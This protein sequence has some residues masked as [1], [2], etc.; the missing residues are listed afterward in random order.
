MGAVGSI[1]LMVAMAV[2]VIA[3]FNLNKEHL[4]LS[5]FRHSSML[6]LPFA[7][8]NRGTN[9]WYFFGLYCF[10]HIL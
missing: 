3:T 1:E 5:F 4:A 6:G 10:C 8:K 2:M 9:I 7:K